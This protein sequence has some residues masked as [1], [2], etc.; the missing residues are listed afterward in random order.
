MIVWPVRDMSGM[1]LRSISEEKHK[2]WR[3]RYLCSGRADYPPHFPTSSPSSTSE[4]PAT[5]ASAVQGFYARSSNQVK[6]APPIYALLLLPVSP[7]R[8]AVPQQL[9]VSV[10]LQ[11]QVARSGSGE[12][13]VTGRSQLDRKE[14][15]VNTLESSQG[16]KR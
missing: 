13:R 12:G 15:K 14:L 2:I 10:S 1:N 8:A 3:V 11:T 5:I 9:C 7:A 6:S 16:I 4:R